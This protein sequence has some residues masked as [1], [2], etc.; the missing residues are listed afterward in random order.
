M[1]LPKTA[2]T[3]ETLEKEVRVAQQKLDQLAAKGNMHKNTAAR[4]KSQL[5]KLVNASKT[6]T[7]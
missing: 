5:M 3:A 1:S 6:K 2:E 7:N 4:K